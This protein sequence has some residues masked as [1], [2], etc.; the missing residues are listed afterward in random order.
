MMKQDNPD[1]GCERISA[2]LM[3]GPA[4]PAIPQAVA[5]LLHETGSEME[6]AAT[7][8]HA[9]PIHHFE[10]SRPNQMWQTDLFTF[11]L[12]RQTGASI[13][14]LSW[15][16]PPASWSATGCVPAYTENAVTADLL[17]LVRPPCWRIFSAESPAL[18][19][20]ALLIPS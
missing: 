13:S 19:P 15:T 9:P 1:W 12:K 6:E 17:M 11:V 16:T 2:L 18:L 20:S 3:R 4:L 8:P 5:R 14:S 7:R 10:R